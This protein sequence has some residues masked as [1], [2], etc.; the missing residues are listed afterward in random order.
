[1]KNVIKNRI[2]YL[3]IF[4][5]IREEKREREEYLNSMNNDDNRHF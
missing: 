4:T 3:Y 2:T 1:M 5:Y